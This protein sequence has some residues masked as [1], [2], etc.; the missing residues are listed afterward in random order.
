MLDVRTPRLSLLVLAAALLGSS[1]ALAPA[2]SAGAA[3][4]LPEPPDFA[5]E[6]Y[7]DA[8]DYSNPEDLQ[9]YPGAGLYGNVTNASIANGQLTATIGSG[10]ALQPVWSVPGSVPWGRDGA[11]AP[12][13]AN[14][15]T[16]ISFS[17]DSAV[18]GAGG[19][20]WFSCRDMTPSCYGGMPI[21]IQAGSH[22]YDLTIRNGFSGTPLQWQGQIV[23]LRLQ[24]PSASGGNTIHLDWLRLYQPV[25]G[26]AAGTTPPEQT[27]R[28]PEPVVLDPSATDGPDYASTVR[29]DAWDFSQPSDV[30]G[31]S[32]V[33]NPTFSGGVL[34]GTNGAPNQNDPQVN[35]PL[36]GSIDG[37]TYH[38]LSF[39]YR[40][41][42][43]FNLS[44]A[45]G[46]G[47]LSRLI[48]QVAGN[49]AAYQDLDDVVT[50]PGWND[51]SID[52]ATNPPSA[53]VDPDVRTRIGW[54][55]QSITS[56]RFDPNEDPGPRSWYLDD[57]R[58]TADPGGSDSFDIRY[59]DNAWKSGTTADIYADTA[60][61]GGTSTLIASRVPV[62]Q[63]VNT[64]HW[65]DS[66]V[67]TGSYWIKVVL[68]DGLSSELSYS[69]APVRIVKQIDPF[70]SYDSASRVPG[71]LRVR[72]WAVDPDSKTSPISVVA[73]VD[74]HGDRPVSASASRPDVGRVLPDYGPNHGFDY[75][76]PVGA[77]QHS[78][79]LYALNTGPGTNRLLSC[80]QVTVSSDPFGSLDGAALSGGTATVRGWAIDPDTGS[81]ITVRTYVDGRY[82]GDATANG[83]RPD[84]AAA[85]PG[86]GSAHG[87]SLPVPAAVGS[88]VC[89]YALNS[90]A[91]SQNTTLGCRRV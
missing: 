37:S 69:S 67:A 63:G 18:S 35:L 84:V 1:A 62:A 70:G 61:G 10:G 91:G 11:A 40:Y 12:I 8:W 78:V 46:G 14:R 50:V 26:A 72:G 83:S 31:T 90:G 54:A 65:Q 86:Y 81:A 22:V 38:H 23:G 53:I 80:K 9:L 77:G 64:F 2:S 87:Y 58:L 21:S 47:T 79:C 85:F 76:L 5:S 56:V 3:S 51:V 28:R 30:A 4:P 33:S 75:V 59:Q 15:Y 49:P 44:G 71:G 82:A 29:G 27:T 42:G 24:P 55:G 25:S 7:H 6:A 16:H 52:L 48:W 66:Q 17:L 39:R 74:G 57:L 20:F 13:D 43:A 68:S 41:D 73:Y 19:L 34:H 60:R 36:A 45:P 32:N 88:T 89:V